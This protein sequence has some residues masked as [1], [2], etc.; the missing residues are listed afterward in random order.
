MPEG[1]RGISVDRAL[2][3]ESGFAEP[4]P[5]SPRGPSGVIV[6]PS[7]LSFLIHMMG[8]RGK[9]SCRGGSR[10]ARRPVLQDV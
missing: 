1:L 10:L 6:H 7:S 9:N 5:L 4:A 2:D 8:L 3:Q